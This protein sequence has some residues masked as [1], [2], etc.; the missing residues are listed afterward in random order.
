MTISLP[1]IY[2][3]TD[4][5]VSGLSHTEQVKRLIEGGAT[6]IQ[7]RDKLGAPKD[8]LHNAEQAL[9]IARKN[10]VRILI[11][12]RVDIAM[13]L[14]ADGV[15]LGQ[16]DMPLDAAR[17]L[18]GPQAIIGFSTHNIAQVEIAA[19]VP[20]DYIAFGP[21]F[22]THTKHDHEPVVG[23]NRLTEVKTLLGDTP[24]VAIGGITEQNL[25]SALDAGADS[26]AIISDLLKEHSKIAEKLK[27]MLAATAD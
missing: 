19:N 27:R 24:V 23:L 22:E 15:H 13:A 18:L 2:P 1:R 16:S 7:L 14:G 6:I 9:T 21:I 26:A 10:N 5:N 25:R 8:F 3:I 11:N 17:A 12:D 4:T 20:P